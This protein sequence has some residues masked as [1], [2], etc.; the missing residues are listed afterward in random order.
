M[1]I[2]ADVESQMQRIRSAQ[3]TQDDALTMLAQRTR[4]LE[5]AE[6]EISRTRQQLQ[7]DRDKLQAD[8]QAVESTRRQLADDIARQQEQ[9]TSQRQAIEADQAAYLARSRESEAALK[10]REEQLARSQSRLEARDAE[11]QRET[12]RLAQLESHCRVQEQELGRRSSELETANR[13]LRQRVEQAEQNV[14]ELIAQLEAA[15]EQVSQRQAMLDQVVA[16]S[17]AIGRRVGDLERLL[18]EATERA[19]HAERD[20]AELAKLADQQRADVESRLTQVTK[21]LRQVQQSRDAALAETSA[22]QRQVASLQAEVQKLAAQ[23]ADRDAHVADFQK[24]FEL[25][26]KKLSEFAAILAE[27]TPQLERGASAMIMV[28]QQHQQIERLTKELAEHKLRVDPTESQRRDQRIIELTEALR[29]ARGQS[30]GNVGVGEVEQR[31]AELLNEVNRLKVEVEKLS[32]ANEEAHRQLQN[33]ADAASAGTV[34]EA[35]IAE[36]N[37]KVAALNAEIERLQSASA[38]ELQDQL[39]RQSRA[40][41]E[42]LAE[43]HRLEAD[44]AAALKVRIDELECELAKVRNS[45]KGGSAG[46]DRTDGRKLREKAEKVSAIAEHL[47]RRRT[48]LQ[49]LRQLLVARSLHAAAE[50]S[51]E[52]SLA[53]TEQK[54]QIAEA[55]RALAEA[56]KEMVRRWARP[57][58]VTTMA[59][60]VAFALICAG[61]SWLLADYLFPARIAASVVLEARTT[62]HGPLSDEAAERWRTW[63]RGLFTDPAFMQVLSKR[64]AE[65]RLDRFASLPNISQ[66]LNDDLTIDASQKGAI[67]LTLAGSDEDETSSLLDVVA[68]TAAAESTR[69]LGNRNDSAWAALTGERNEGG[70][71]HYAAVNPVPISDDRIKY[72]GVIFAIVFVSSLGL[73]AAL[74][75]RLARA[76]RVFDQ[77]HAALFTEA[78]LGTA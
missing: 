23:L 74:Y 21:E 28:E 75:T 14:G 34:H 53:I 30:A 40:H 7:R 64:L 57:R 18:H 56:E 11:L 15:N 16:E 9:L 22:S 19:D 27:Q 73:M 43:S 2:I 1:R 60:I 65:R 26:A 4:S 76:K 70:R 44:A 33:Q 35:L 32:L 41:E 48:R 12:S 63:H 5:Q 10:A 68:A 62:A 24:K 3:K 49:K 31:N 25:T 38:A 78:R 59:W 20:T 61:G 67:I 54:Q 37:A 71:V 45:K 66:T 77:E 8:L 42:R 39:D 55:R 51:P 72:A 58:A 46:K 52:E 6:D 29:Q 47:R 17:A 69:R 36:H 50:Q 13:E